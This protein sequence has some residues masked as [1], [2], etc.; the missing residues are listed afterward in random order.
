MSLYE[1]ATEDRGLHAW[2]QSV[3]EA[4][5]EN[6]DPLGKH[7]TARVAPSAVTD[8]TYS[9]SHHAQQWP[10]YCEEL[11]YC[12]LLC[13]PDLSMMCDETFIG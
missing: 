5:S 12:A 1:A 10:F 8:T 4:R 9:L 13:A 11:R 3:V 7:A 2:C 6:A